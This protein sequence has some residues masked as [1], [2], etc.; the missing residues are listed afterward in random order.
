AASYGYDD[1]YRLTNVEGDSGESWTYLYDDVGNLTFKSDVG[2]YRYGETGAPATCLT[3]AGDQKFTYSARGEMEQT[4]WGIL[5]FSPEGRLVRIVSPGGAQM[6]LSYNHAGVRVAER[7]RGDTTPPVNRL[8]PDAL[9][10]IDNGELIL[11]LFDGQG[12][13]ARQAADGTRLYFHPDH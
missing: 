6:S 13:A 12:T 1:L 4:P 3:S 5:S 9:Y 11:N 10:S 7:G 2:E 8:T